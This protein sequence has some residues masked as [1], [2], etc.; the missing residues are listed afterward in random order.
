[1]RWHVLQIFQSA[2]FA[3]GRLFLRHF[4]SAN[5]SVSS[6]Q[7]LAAKSPVPPNNLSIF[8]RIPAKTSLR[9]RHF[10]AI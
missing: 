1:M 7:T 10:E 6:S 8:S 3:V 5:G 9:I 4:K 2:D